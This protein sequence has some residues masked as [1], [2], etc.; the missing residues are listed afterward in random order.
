MT[1]Q[2]QKQRFKTC[3]I[4]PIYTCTQAM[5]ERGSVYTGQP[6]QTGQHR[7]DCLGEDLG[8]GKV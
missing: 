2:G 3:T 6:N 1:S 4:Y 8:E 5:V 7:R